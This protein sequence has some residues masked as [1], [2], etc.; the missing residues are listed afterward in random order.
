MTSIDGRTGVV[1]DFIFFTLDSLHTLPGYRPA[2]YDIVN[3]VVVDS[4]Q[5]QYTYRVAA[6]FPVK[7]LY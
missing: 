1:D 4:I 2:L 5:S 7:T 6:M 3:V